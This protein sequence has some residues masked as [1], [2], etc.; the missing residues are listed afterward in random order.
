MNVNDIKQ[1][2]KVYCQFERHFYDITGHFCQFS[3]LDTKKV[4]EVL[5]LMI[6]D[7]EIVQPQKNTY[8]TH[9]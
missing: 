6:K 2:I 4:E 7:K 8:K 1:R 5:L 9:I 3:G